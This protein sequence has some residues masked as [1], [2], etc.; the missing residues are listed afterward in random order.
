MEFLNNERR[1]LVSFSERLL[2][3]LGSNYELQGKVKEY[4]QQLSDN[5]SSGL[6]PFK[7][8]GEN[9]HIKDFEVG[10]V[11]Y[12]LLFLHFVENGVEILYLLFCISKTGKEFKTYFKGFRTPRS[13]K[14]L[15]KYIEKNANKKTILSQEKIISAIAKINAPI[16][17]PDVPQLLRAWIDGYKYKSES[18]FFETTTWK[19]SVLKNR[20]H[21]GSITQLLDDMRSIQLKKSDSIETIPF[22]TGYPFLMGYSLHNISVLCSY[23]SYESSEGK[24]DMFILYSMFVGKPTQRDYLELISTYSLDNVSINEDFIIKSAVKA[25]PDYLLVNEEFLESILDDE[26][27]N[28][29]LSPEQEKALIEARFPLFINGQAGSGKTTMLYYIFADFFARRQKEVIPHNIIYITQNKELLKES[30]NRVQK[31][32]EYNPKFSDMKIDTTSLDK[33]FS[34]LYNLMNSLL[35]ESEKDKFDI[36]KQMTFGLFKHEFNSRYVKTGSKLSP[37]LVWY[38][39]RAFIKGYSIDKEIDNF[40]DLSR[41]DKK[42]V[43]I[44]TFREVLKVYSWYKTLLKNNAYWDEQDLATK[45]IEGF[46]S[47]K[48][49]SYGII[50]CDEA[51]DFTRKEL[52]FIVRLL[53]H[54]SCDLTNENIMPAIF[55]GDPYQTINPTGFKWKNVEAMV[56]NEFKR[57]VSTGTTKI[58]LQHVELLH[59]FR[60]SPA[61]INLSNV[62]QSLRFTYLEFRDLKPQ[63]EYKIKKTITPLFV[64]L[65]RTSSGIDIDTL[66]KFAVENYKET[67]FILS[68]EIISSSSGVKS[69]EIEDDEFLSIFK[70]N[71]AEDESIINI[72]TASS[73]KGREIYNIVLYKFGEAAPIDLADFMN[74]DSEISENHRFE[75]YH[76]FN[77]LYVALTRAEEQLSIFDTES[78]FNKLWKHLQNVDTLGKIIS[79]ISALD[80]EGGSINEW[81]ECLERILSSTDETHQIIKIAENETDLDSVADKDPIRNAQRYEKFGMLNEDPSRLYQASVF[82]D[83]VNDQPNANKCKAYAYYFEAKKELLQG[84]FNQA[85]YEKAGDAFLSTNLP[86]KET[87]AKDTYWEGA[88]FSQ[89]S[90]KFVSGSSWQ[91][92]IA[93]YCTQTFKS[94]SLQKLRKA[95]E[96]EKHLHKSAKLPMERLADRIKMDPYLYEGGRDE[97]LALANFF[98]DL[99]FHKTIPVFWDLAGNLFYKSDGYYDIAKDCW[100]KSGKKNSAKYHWVEY[101]LANT[102]EERVKYLFQV[103][104]DEEIDWLL[105]TNTKS[106][107]A[108]ILDIIEK[109]KTSDV[110]EWGEATQIKCFEILSQQ[111]SNLFTSL[112]GK[113]KIDYTYSLIFDF[114]NSPN[115]DQESIQEKLLDIIWKTQRFDLLSKHK[116]DTNFSIKISTFAIECFNE[117]G[118][119]SSTINNFVGLLS[120]VSRNTIN[121]VLEVAINKF[122]EK[123]KYLK[124]ERVF[125]RVSKKNIGIL[126][127]YTVKFYKE[128]KKFSQEHFLYLD[129]LFFL[130]KSQKEEVVFKFYD[131]A[132]KKAAKANN[133]NLK[134]DIVK[135]WKRRGGNPPEDH[136][137]KKV[138]R[139]KYGSMNL[140]G[141]FV[142]T[143][144]DKDSPT[145]KIEWE[146]IKIEISISSPRVIIHCSDGSSD[147]VKIGDRSLPLNNF[148]NPIKNLDDNTFISQHGNY[149]GEFIENGIRFMRKE[150]VLTITLSKKEHLKPKT[151]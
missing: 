144:G 128:N 73:F 118:F 1:I 12:R 28:L 49:L 119:E 21:S 131:Y 140:S 80:G 126:E 42:L 16:E 34:T 63:S 7:K 46:D 81:K 44:D 137:T 40:N 69:H 139:K 82:Y 66:K 37:E 78:G 117:F 26:D 62:I 147:T 58:N 29:A 39:I 10:G 104:R 75:L 96:Q 61:I 83:R 13:Q 24:K 68:K 90:R 38:V 6:V 20:N 97:L 123:E 105:D 17:K 36:G 60:C 77:K 108:I 114:S 5:F 100:D 125:E 85:M 74:S 115:Q 102:D 106:A 89:I 51:Q 146:N 133:M 148:E 59:N 127:N 4:A 132:L 145:A 111:D 121:R 99:G 47:N 138:L 122:Y 54:A 124:E 18:T 45:A 107:E 19:P 3:E 70:E 11:E 35:S 14:D 64:Y 22:D 8:I 141:A 30:K 57:L 76:Y 43:S 109:S 65:D 9:W 116:D 135:I 98:K 103:N 120:C 142:Q 101:H 56:T 91:D 33:H 71:K 23:Y 27:A 136:P 2:A 84:R 53:E 31:L 112:I 72:E 151:P 143:G 113:F 52:S 95:L 15:T 41:E 32:F 50:I 93:E 92:R 129:N 134:R 48:N 25:Y 55:A 94:D 88:C 149:R 79:V 130:L 150:S 86:D 87:M 110:V 67:I